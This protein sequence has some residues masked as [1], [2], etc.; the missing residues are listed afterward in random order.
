MFLFGRSS[1]YGY[2]TACLCIPSVRLGVLRLLIQVL[3]GGIFAFFLRRHLVV[4][5]VD[6]RVGM[7]SVS[8]AK[9]LYHFTWPPAVARELWLLHTLTLFGI[10][11]LPFQPFKCLMMLSTFSF[12]KFICLGNGL[13]KAYKDF[14]G[15]CIS[16][17][18]LLQQSA[19]NAVA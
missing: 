14:F 18:G 8:T 13:V 15:H 19:T 3:C 10:G 7:Y 17:L 16:F 2:A 11:S 5:L 12:S 6:H 1:L 9:R 4:G